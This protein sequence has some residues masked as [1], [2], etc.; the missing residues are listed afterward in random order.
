M[1]GS[2]ITM[3]NLKLSSKKT[4]LDASNNHLYDFP[5]VYKPTRTSNQVL[6]TCFLLVCYRR[7]DN[8]FLSTLATFANALSHIYVNRDYF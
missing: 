5:G 3:H 2:E 8:H 4:L 7:L 1:G 6:F